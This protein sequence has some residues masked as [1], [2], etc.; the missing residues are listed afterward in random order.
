MIYTVTCLINCAQLVYYS[1]IFTCTKQ[2]MKMINCVCYVVSL[3]NSLN[4]MGV[5]GSEWCCILNAL[6]VKKYIKYMSLQKYFVLCFHVYM[7]RVVGICLWWFF[8]HSQL[9][10]NST[11]SNLHTHWDF[12]CLW[13]SVVF[14]L[15]MQGGL[16]SILRTNA[17]PGVYIVY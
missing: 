4:F 17:V 15:Q 10:T 3:K 9:P 5:S 16:P 7:L 13:I 2:Y 11:Q 8:I 6:I 12:C 14:P 1:L